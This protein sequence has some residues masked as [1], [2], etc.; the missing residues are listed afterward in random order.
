MNEKDREIIKKATKKE[1]EN[2]DFESV[3][4]EEMKRLGQPLPPEEIWEKLKE[5]TEKNKKF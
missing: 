1:L 5:K 3:S 2:Y 4:D